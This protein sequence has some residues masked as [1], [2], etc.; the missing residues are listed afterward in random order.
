M[1]NDQLLTS[2]N[3]Q[4][5][6]VGA[7]LIIAIVS[8]A[9]TVYFAVNVP[10]ET[11]KCEFIHSK[12]ITEDFV[13]LSSAI[14]SLS[15]AESSV[16]S[17]SAPIKMA[18]TKE[19]I[20]ASPLSPGSISFVPTEEKAT[21][22]LDESGTG[23]TGTW[24]I[25]N[26][27]GN[28]SVVYGE[29]EVKDNNLT[30]APTC[31][32]ACINSSFDTGSNN[33]IYETI[34]WNATTPPYTEIV[35]EVR[36]SIYADMS[37]STGWVKVENGQ[38]LSS[39]MPTLKGHRYIQFRATFITYDPSKR[40]SLVDLR[41][42]YASPSESITLVSSSG[43]ISFTSNYHYLPSQELT[44]ENG[45]VIKNQTEGG[46]MI[47]SF[48]FSFNNASGVPRI[49]ISLVNLTGSNVTQSGVATSPVRINFIEHKLISD[50]FF[51]PSLVLNISTAHPYICE[52][53]LNKTFEGC[54]IN[55]TAGTVSIGFYEHERGVQLYLE[56]TT[57]EVNI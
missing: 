22:K 17:I 55:S 7:V 14:N 53:W 34:S 12:E 21:V 20:I 32:Y 27:T 43:F 15:H 25:S 23:T 33:T 10:I 8:T 24:L 13:D 9:I 6:V 56:E 39:I 52:D 40:P 47:R 4:A 29:V 30:L 45:A 37:N 49:N 54:N 35:I 2:T 36:T 28:F 5:F 51:Y 42:N 31:S 11:K 26:F 1:K 16:A 18:P 19:S 44:Y 57:V 38:N 50:Y 41:V 48:N 3:A 46:I